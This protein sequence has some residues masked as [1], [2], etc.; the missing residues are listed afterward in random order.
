MEEEGLVAKRLRS[1]PPDVQE[2]EERLSS[3]RRKIAEGRAASRLAA[4]HLDDQLGGAE[5]GLFDEHLKSLSQEWMRL[6]SCKMS[7]GLSSPGMSESELSA[8]A[9][10]WLA[11]AATT[12]RRPTLQDSRELEKRM[13]LLSQQ[14]NSVS[15]D[16]YLAI[17]EFSSSDAWEDFLLLAEA[18]QRAL[19]QE[20]MR[21]A[22]QKMDPDLSAMSESDRAAEVERL[23]Q[24]KLQEAH[25]L[26]YQ[27]NIHRFRELQGMARIID[28]DPKQRG[29]YYN[30]VSY[31]VVDLATFDHSEESPAGPM[32]FTDR[33]ADKMIVAVDRAAINILSVKIACSDIGFP[34]Q[35]HGAVFA[36]DCVEYKRVYLFNR[37]SD[38]C[39]LINSEKEAL[40]L[41][42]PKRG[43]ALSYRDDYVETDLWVKD[44]NG[45]CRQFSRGIL[46]RQ[47][48]I[49]TKVRLK[50]SLW[51]PGSAPWT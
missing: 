3:L 13:D 11:E 47:L 18:R 33:P 30:S 42:G 49:W 45:Y 10:P 21:L 41:T 44:C 37:D 17:D 5:I 23:R 7:L 14:I 22:S 43:L 38:H 36:R 40:I 16:L 15:R 51:L 19:L 32:R 48:R 8:E 12:G 24:E 50:E 28:F 29:M 35:V 34:I 20:L 27:G 9:L 26:V 6:A 46:A 2:L 39:Q 4:P 25:R 1:G 31:V